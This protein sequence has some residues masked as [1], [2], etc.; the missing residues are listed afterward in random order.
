MAS[1]G[2][3]SPILLALF[4]VG[5]VSS[6]YVALVTDDQFKRVLFLIMA[7]CAAGNLALRLR[8]RR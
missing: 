8:T 7:L 1:A 3:S 6:T 4:A 5:V 2:G